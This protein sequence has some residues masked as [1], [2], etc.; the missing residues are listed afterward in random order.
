V[1]GSAAGISPESRRRGRVGRS[2]V[3]AARPPTNWLLTPAPDAE[4]FLLWVGHNWGSEWMRTLAA[5]MRDGVIVALDG[6]PVLEAPPR[7][8]R[9][10]Y[11]TEAML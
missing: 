3:S 10:T 2:A 5:M 6:E 1:Y 4:E 7:P 9:V 11:R 8:A